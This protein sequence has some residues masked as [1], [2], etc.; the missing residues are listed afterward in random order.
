MVF[1]FN[2]LNTSLL[3]VKDRE[4]LNLEKIKYFNEEILK[5]VK[6]NKIY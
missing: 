5:I 4:S 3:E 2:E 1:I 6:L